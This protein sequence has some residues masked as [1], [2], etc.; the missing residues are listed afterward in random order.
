M[1]KITFST[2]LL[3]TIILFSCETKV[4][5]NADYKD[6]TVVYAAIN[7]NDT[8]HYVKINRA[9]L[10]DGVSA[11][12]LAANSD[13]FNY[14]K[15][16]LSVMVDELRGDNGNFV[17]TYPLT[18]TINERPKNPGIFANDSNVLFKFTA[19]I[20]RNNLYKLKIINN[21]LNKLITSETQ[22]VGN[23]TIANPATFNF[24]IGTAND[25]NLNS[26][27]KTISVK[28]GNNM[29]R[30][31]ARLI[32]NYTNFFNDS[33]F[34]AE[35]I[36]MRLGEMKTT[37]NI[38]GESLDWSISSATFFDNLMANIPVTIPNLSHRKPNLVTLEFITTGTDLN[39]F[40]EVSE[41]S[42]NLNQEKPAFT[43]IE[44]GLGI[45]SSRSREFWTTTPPPSGTNLSN[46]TYKRLEVLGLGFCGTNSLLCPF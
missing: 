46:D 37:T 26:K 43:N 32:F 29:G 17:Q 42:N 30:V 22:I 2:L 11:T 8:E 23:L 28:S 21:K 25:G 9:F 45:F 39:V 1:N 19:T 27:D 31:E 40:M 44:N 20:N 5:I 12:D 41:P 7:P 3:A 35:R 14:P 24:W 13:N 36:V 15:D 10:Q 6:I 38:A 34:Q 4:D 16:E 33:S 18:R